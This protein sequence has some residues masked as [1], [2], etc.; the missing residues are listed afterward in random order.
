MPVAQRV[1][2]LVCDAARTNL[3]IIVFRLHRGQ[4]SKSNATAIAWETG[5]ICFGSRCLLLLVS[6][7]H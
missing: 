5:T 7:R 4:K 6:F 1:H 3:E 2:F